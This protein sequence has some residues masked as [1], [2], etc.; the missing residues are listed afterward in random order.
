MIDP[1]RRRSGVEIVL[2]GDPAY[3]MG[4]RHRT[5]RER[6]TQYRNDH[7]THAEPLGELPPRG[8]QSEL[9]EEREK[10]RYGNEHPGIHKVPAHPH[11]VRGVADSEQKRKE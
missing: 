1:E 7:A 6:L 11:Q 4:G 2:V 10:W 9:V 5:W 3:E 8:E